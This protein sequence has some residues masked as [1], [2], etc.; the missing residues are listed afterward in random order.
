MK[1]RHTRFLGESPPPLSA[2]G[3]E[4]KHAFANSCVHT[5][6]CA[7]VYAASADRL[8]A[9]PATPPASQNYT[10][11]PSRGQFELQASQKYKPVMTTRQSELQASKKYTPSEPESRESFVWWYWVHRCPG[12][13]LRN[14][15][16]GTQSRVGWP[17][18]SRLTTRYTGVGDGSQVCYPRTFS[19]CL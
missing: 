7:A 11:V 16:Q 13:R 6:R 9:C 14:L 3:C 19:E 10:P 5:L 8:Y 17:E 1:E 2:P 12:P 15:S 4:S 18:S